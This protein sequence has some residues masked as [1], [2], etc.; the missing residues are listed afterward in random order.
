MLRKATDAAKRKVVYIYGQWRL[1]A[2]NCN[3][4]DAVS[5]THIIY[6]MGFCFGGMPQFVPLRNGINQIGGKQNAKGTAARIGADFSGF[7][8]PSSLHMHIAQ[9]QTET[10][11]NTA[12]RGRNRSL[13][14]RPP[15]PSFRI[16][17]VLPFSHFRETCKNMDFW[18]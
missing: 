13:P 10:E 17:Q 7:F 1:P 14:P 6:G 15:L 4:S 16:P 3:G 2:Q 12:R 8:P 18:R 5:S 11:I 9:T